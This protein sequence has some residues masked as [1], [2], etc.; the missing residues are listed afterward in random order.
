[1]GDIYGGDVPALGLSGDVIAASFGKVAHRKLTREGIEGRQ[2]GPRLA[3]RY[4]AALLRHYEEGL[5]LVVLAIANSIPGLKQLATALGLVRFAEM[6]AASVAM[7]GSCRAHDV[8]L[9]LLRMVSNNIGQLSVLYAEQAGL[10]RVVFGGSFIRDHPFTIATIS[11][12]VHFFSRG[13]IQPFFLKH[14]G[15]VGAIGA[16]LAGRSIAGACER[17][18][19]RDSPLE[20]KQVEVAEPQEGG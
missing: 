4:L 14:D 18:P 5:W 16:H 10:E 15:F 8:A 12:A 13:R 1:V 9:S 7:C 3:L 11:S 19:P 2:L 6:R 20:D 17:L